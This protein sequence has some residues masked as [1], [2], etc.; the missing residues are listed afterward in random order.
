MQGE[1]PY[2]LQHQNLLVYPE[3]H[4]LPPL[5]ANPFENSGA[6]PGIP[7]N[8]QVPPPVNIIYL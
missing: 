2:Y 5:F 8:Y 7:H 3:Q 1:I 4:G 6:G